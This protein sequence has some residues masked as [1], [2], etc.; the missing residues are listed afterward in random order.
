APRGRGHR[1]DPGRRR[2]R[3]P[4]GTR[5]VL[6]RECPRQGD[7]RGVPVRTAGDRR[8]LGSRGGCPRRCAGP[9][10]GSL[11]GRDGPRR[12]EPGEA[13]QRHARHPTGAANGEVPLRG[14]TGATDRP[15]GNDRG[16]LPRHDRRGAVGK[17][18]V[19]LRP[20]LPSPPSGRADY[21]RAPTG[22]EG[23][24]Q[25]PRPRLSGHPPGP[26]PGTRPVRPRGPAPGA[27]GDPM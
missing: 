6:C 16:Y 2:G 3:P 20:R 9:A 24:R 23:R 10:L 26:P 18:R 12:P 17:P 22:R 5:H 13:A 7:C 21:G 11:R 8:R 1:V 14:R 27:R 25:P 4:A 19:R 15:A